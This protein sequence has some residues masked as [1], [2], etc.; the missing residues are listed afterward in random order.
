MNGRIF[1]FQR[2]V[3]CPKWTPASMSDRRERGGSPGIRGGR[4][5]SWAPSE[6]SVV[7]SVIARSFRLFPPLS[8]PRK[9]S[10]NGP[11]DTELEGCAVEERVEFRGPR[12]RGGTPTGTRAPVGGW[13]AKGTRDAAKVNPGLGRSGR[14]FDRVSA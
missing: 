7:T 11:A 10:G 8:P 9:S 4:T 12:A 2:L 3:W 5:C 1:G 13:D 14:G 6:I